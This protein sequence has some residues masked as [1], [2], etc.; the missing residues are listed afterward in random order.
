MDQGQLKPIAEEV[1]SAMAGLPLKAQVEIL[2]NVLMFMGVSHMD[3]TP[4]HIT[5][6]NI[7]QVVFTDRQSNGETVANALALQGLVMMAWLEEEKPQ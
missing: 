2:A 4:E 7:A 6:N 5:P 1:R 3:D